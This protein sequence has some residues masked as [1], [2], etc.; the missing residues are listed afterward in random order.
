MLEAKKGLIQITEKGGR[1]LERGSLGVATR[2]I[3]CFTHI[4]WCL[5]PGVL[6]APSWLTAFFKTGGQHHQVVSLS[7]CCACLQQAIYSTFQKISYFWVMRSMVKPENPR[8]PT[9]WRTP[10]A[11]GGFV[12]RSNVGFGTSLV[13]QWLRIHFAM[14]GMWVWSLVG[15]LRFHILWGS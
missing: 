5:D 4:L 10:F 6:A 3:T 15:E 13:V 7:W 9:H 8:A 12:I 1:H 2:V 11:V 14:Q